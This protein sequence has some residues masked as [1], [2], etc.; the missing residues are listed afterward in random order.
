LRRCYAEFRKHCIQTHDL[1]EWD[2][3]PHVYL[4]LKSWLLTLTK[5]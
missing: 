2:T 1:Q 5:T 3:P 4:D